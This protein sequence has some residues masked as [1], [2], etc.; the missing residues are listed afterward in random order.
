VTVRDAGR[1]RDAILDAAEAQFAERGFDGASLSDI[2]AAAAL[3]RGAPSYFFGSKEALYRAVL[4]RVFAHRQAATAA[5]MEPVHAWCA[6]D[7]GPERLRAALER[8]VAGYMDFVLER[9]AFARFVARE[10]LAGAR[11]LRA[12]RRDS[13]ALE[14]AFTAVHAVAR[15]RGLRRFAV[16]DA[17]LL[18]VALAYAPLAHENTLLA[19]LGTDLRERAAH[20]RHAKLTAG[21]LMHL[22]A[23]PPAA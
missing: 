18:F 10:E 19:S 12:V 13:H 22:L 5:A 9:P 7:G 3:S 14:D 17:V 4:E 16:A 20:R 11:R 21:Q 8:A 2:G 15:R 1:S 23:G 6:G